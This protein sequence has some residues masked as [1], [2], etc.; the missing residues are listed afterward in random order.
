MA[1]PKSTG[2]IKERHTYFITPTLVRKIKIIA[3]QEG[4]SEASHV[5]RAITDYITKW[6]KKNGE[7]KLK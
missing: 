5:E 4:G 6:E 2:E 3:V 7:I 1:R